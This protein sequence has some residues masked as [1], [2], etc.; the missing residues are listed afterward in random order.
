M[1]V[2][3]LAALEQVVAVHLPQYNAATG[4]QH[5]N[6]VLHQFTHHF[7]LNI[8]KRRFTLALKKFAN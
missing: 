4:G 2:N 5:A 7:L 1:Q 8:T 3:R 6:P